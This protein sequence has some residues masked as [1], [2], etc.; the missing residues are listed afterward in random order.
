[1]AVQLQQAGASQPRTQ[2]QEE[3]NLSTLQVPQLQVMQQPQIQVQQQ[4]SPGYMI[5]QQGAATQ[6]WPQA[7]QFVVRSYKKL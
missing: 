7:T 6:Q 4:P 5:T 2:P 1:M 3:A